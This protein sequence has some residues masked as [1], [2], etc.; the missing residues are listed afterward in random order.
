MIGRSRSKQGFGLSLSY[1][2][3]IQCVEKSRADEKKMKKEMR[4]GDDVGK[5]AISVAKYWLG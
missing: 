1:Q 2:K 3:V 4:K 5:K